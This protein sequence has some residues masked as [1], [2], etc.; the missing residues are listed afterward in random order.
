MYKLFKDPRSGQIESVNNSDTGGTIPF[1]PANIDYQNF[2][3]QIDNGS[4]QLEDANGVL[5]TPTQAK[6]YVAT[7]P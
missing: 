1:D 4:A 3:I 5:M 6:A 2:K 7:L